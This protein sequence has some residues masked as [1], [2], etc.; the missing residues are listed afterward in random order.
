[1]YRNQSSGTAPGASP[2]QSMANRRFE[3][4]TATIGDRLHWASFAQSDP[5]AGNTRVLH[6][7]RLRL[8]F[9]H[10]AAVLG[11]PLEAKKVRKCGP[12]AWQ[13]MVHYARR[14]TDPE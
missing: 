4:R 3:I 10:W 9:E 2:A 11:R 6:Y 14:R 5:M 7:E 8:R 13:R 12:C 1:M